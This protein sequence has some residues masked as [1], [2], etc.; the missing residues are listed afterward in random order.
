MTSSK[1]RLPRWSEI[2][3]FIGRGGARP[4]RLDRAYTIQ[5]LRTMARRRTPRAV[6]D[7]TDGGAEDETSMR[8]ARAAFKRVEFR[9]RVLRDVASV[10]TTTTLLGKPSAM[11]LVL[12]PTGFTRM[13]QHEGEIAVARAA[14]QAGIPYALSTLG[15]TSIE[16]LA[17]GA[18]QTDRWFQLYMWKDRGRSKEL[19]SRAQEAGYSALIL[20]VDVPV[21]GARLRDLRNG[22]TIPPALTLR[23]LMGMARYPRWWLNVLTTEPLRFAS[24]SDSPG[25]VASI[26]NSMFDPSVSFEDV[27]WI[28][29]TW[30]GPVVV[31]G[32]QRV[33]DARRVADLGVEAL[34]ISNHGGRQLDRAPTTLELLPQVVDAV[35]DRLEV[36]LDSGVRT[37]SDIAAAVAGGARACLVGRAYLYGLM[38]G[39]QAGVKRAIT[40]LQTEL[41]RTMQLLGAREVTELTPDLVNLRP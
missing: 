15:T 38:A 36:Y 40:I 31:K 16:D 7:Y 35:G 39:G 24:I 4:S 5:D 19:I 1:R 28:R 33:D 8:R 9:P 20:T 17:A 6:F 30:N 12:A 32:I 29:G 34:V 41:V 21:A 14:A 10:D 27:E 3:P 18:P 2:K 13:M 37:G 23:T 26:I 25:A 22:L 11:P